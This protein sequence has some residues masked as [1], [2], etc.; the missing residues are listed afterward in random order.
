MNDTIPALSPYIEP[1]PV[2]FTFEA[3]GWYAVGVLLAL[4]AITAVIL[5]IRHYYRNR[6][7]HLAIRLVEE[8]EKVAIAGGEYSKLVYNANMIA[9]QICI[10]LYGRKETA[11]LKDA[12]WIIFLNRSSGSN[13]FSSA[14]AQIIRDVYYPTVHTGKQQALHFTEKIKQWI[15]K[16]RSRL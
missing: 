4:G 8:N 14:D 3:P 15:K 9:K 7:R 12:P 6:Y 5:W 2:I 16:H 1:S 13:I 10:R 11:S